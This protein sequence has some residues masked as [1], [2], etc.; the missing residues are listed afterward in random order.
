MTSV[1]MSEL[2]V[3]LRMNSLHV[4]SKGLCGSS[5]HK[6]FYSIWLTST[7]LQKA[8][9]N[10]PYGGVSQQAIYQIFR[11]QRRCHTPPSSQPNDPQCHRWHRPRPPEPPATPCGSFPG[12]FCCWKKWRRDASCHH[13]HKKR[14]S[15]NI[16][17]SQAVI[18]N[19]GTSPF[20]LPLGITVSATEK[21]TTFW[22]S[23]R[24][25]PPHR[26][27]KSPTDP[28]CTYSHPPKKRKN[29]RQPPEYHLFPS[30]TLKDVCFLFWDGTHRKSDQVP[31]CSNVKACAHGMIEMWRMHNALSTKPVEAIGRNYPK[32]CLFW[33]PCTHR[34]MSTTIAAETSQRFHTC[35]RLINQVQIPTW[36][37][38]WRLPTRTSR[39][40]AS[41][42]F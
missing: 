3:I 13:F 5:I 15:Q 40:H 26:A 27:T 22:I 21:P 2:L 41:S 35:H 39:A 23:R 11:H 33:Q 37:L 6:Y 1:P 28:T 16:E 31:T 12:S 4:N 32:L 38:H 29:M 10:F 7:N 20:V 34:N 42:N 36:L 17:R 9:A 18:G 30:Y 24:P 8:H 19:A 25:P 14:N